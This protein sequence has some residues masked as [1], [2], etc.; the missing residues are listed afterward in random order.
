M[1]KVILRSFGAFPIFPIFDDLVSRKMAAS[2]A[3]RIQIRALGGSYLYMKYFRLLRF[4]NQS[5]VIWYIS[6]ISDFQQTCILN[7][8]GRRIK[9]TK[10]W[11]SGVGI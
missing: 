10:I 8:T 7:T 6:K 5:K 9:W 11:A 3:N 4:K 2:R 1:F